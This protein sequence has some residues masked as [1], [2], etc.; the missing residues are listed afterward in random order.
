MYISLPK[1]R[2]LEFGHEK[3]KNNKALHAHRPIAYEYMSQRIY[4]N[5]EMW[6]ANTSLINSFVTYLI[7][8]NNRLQSEKAIL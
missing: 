6:P 4:N 3:V 8:M 5:S 7:P 2:V 1:Y